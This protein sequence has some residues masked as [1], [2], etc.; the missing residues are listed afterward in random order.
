MSD[1]AQDYTRR[2]G[3]MRRNAGFT[4]FAI[5]IAGLG[6]GAACTVFSV[7]SACSSVAAV[8]AIQ[9]GWYGFPTTTTGP[10]PR[11]EHSRSLRELNQYGLRSGGLVRILP[12][13]DEELTGTDKPRAS[14]PASVTENFFALLGVQ[15]AIG[16]TFAEECQGDIPLRRPCS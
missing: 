2:F 14:R 15:T 7:V 13:H 8:R 12:G 6:I 16:R 4:A 10:P 11:P 3:G 1:L 9:D 5:L